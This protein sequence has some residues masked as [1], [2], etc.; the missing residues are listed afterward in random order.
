M[1]RPYSRDSGAYLLIIQVKKRLKITPG[2]LG[3]LTLN[4]GSYVY[5]G[6]AMRNLESRIKRHHQKRKKL[7]W[8][9]DYLLDSAD[10]AKSLPI[11]SAR[12]IECALAGNI[13]QIAQ[14]SVAGFGCSD[15]SCPSH[16]HYFPDDP[17][18]N[19]RFLFIVQRYRSYT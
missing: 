6:S 10:L 2:S 8:H 5:V 11:R 12:R 13:A 18:K 16:L 3:T 17:L 19:E 15:C 7:Y 14:S 4:S 1:C 9:V